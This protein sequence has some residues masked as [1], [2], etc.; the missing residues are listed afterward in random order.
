[1]RTRGRDDQRSGPTRAARPSPRRT[2][3]KRSRAPVQSPIHRGS[4]DIL[5]AKITPWL[6]VPPSGTWLALSCGMMAI[7]VV[8]G[9][10]CAVGAFPL[11]AGVRDFERRGET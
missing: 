1:M 8:V 7:V 5:P 3:V 9:G 2:L 4:P 11:R 10:S 6:L